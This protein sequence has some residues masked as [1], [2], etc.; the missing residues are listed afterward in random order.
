MIT[1]SQF[2]FWRDECSGFGGAFVKAKK[3][4][5]PPNT[6]SSSLT[7]RHG[8]WPY[9]SLATGPKPGRAHMH[10]AERPCWLSEVKCN[11]TV[12]T[13]AANSSSYRLHPAAA[14]MGVKRYNLAT[15]ESFSESSISL[16]VLPR[17]PCAYGTVRVGNRVPLKA[18]QTRPYANAPTLYSSFQRS[19]LF[20]ISGVICRLRAFAAAMNARCGIYEIL[21]LKTKGMEKG[22]AHK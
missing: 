7:R 21:I 4:T 20:S 18:W 16:H 19:N 2:M 22:G 8:T 6:P 1:P 10:D 12:A 14:S 13:F 15:Y 9:F 3:R 11:A 5:V 17:P